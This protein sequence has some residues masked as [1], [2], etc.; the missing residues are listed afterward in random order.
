MKTRLFK[1]ADLFENKMQVGI[2]NFFNNR[3]TVVSIES[4]TRLYYPSDL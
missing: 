2:I 4:W 1:S 3:N